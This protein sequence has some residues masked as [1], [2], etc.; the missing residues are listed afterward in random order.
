MTASDQMHEGNASVGT[1]LKRG[2]LF[3]LIGLVLYA[4]VYAAA[5]RLAASHAKRNQIGRAHV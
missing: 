2:A 1:F 3:V 5:D 4:L